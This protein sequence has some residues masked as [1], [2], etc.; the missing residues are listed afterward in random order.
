LFPSHV[1]EN[2]DEPMNFRIAHLSPST[3]TGLKLECAG[4]CHADP[5]GMHL[6]RSVQLSLVY[7]PFSIM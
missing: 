5:F 2:L 4:T 6:E 1:T 3:V 7:V